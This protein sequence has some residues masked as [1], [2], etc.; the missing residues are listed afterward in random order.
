MIIFTCLI[1]VPVHRVLD[2]VRP[3]VVVAAPHHGH[4][5]VADVPQLTLRHH[6]DLVLGAV[7]VV[8]LGQGGGVQSSQLQ[9]LVSLRGTIFVGRSMI[10]WFWR[11]SMV[12]I[13]SSTMSISSLTISLT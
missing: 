12:A 3:V 5:L 6:V 9:Y 4:V 13:V 7:H 2:S 8:E 10:C 11:R 1:R